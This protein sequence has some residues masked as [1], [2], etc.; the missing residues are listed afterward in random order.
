MIEKRKIVF[1]RVSVECRKSI[2]DDCT[3]AKYFSDSP[4]TR[5]T[6]LSEKSTLGKQHHPLALSW[7]VSFL[8]MRAKLDEGLFAM[9]G[10][11]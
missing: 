6:S 5:F 9:A 7:N 11:L 8:N 4:L 3:L 10:T 2:L 1:N